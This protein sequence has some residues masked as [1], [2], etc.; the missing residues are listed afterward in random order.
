MIAF[1]KWRVENKEVFKKRLFEI[2]LQSIRLPEDSP[3]SS[4]HKEIGAANAM[5]IL[6][7]SKYDFSDQDLSNI[8]IAGAVLA[9]GKFRGANLRG[10]DLSCCLTEG[11]D[12]SGATLTGNS[13]KPLPLPPPSPSP[14][15]PQPSSQPSP[16]P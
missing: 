9:N 6:V 3:R 11:A 7:A 5:T 4:K 13:V 2:I 1:L 10:V 15:S 14:A 8:R 12:F 16:Q